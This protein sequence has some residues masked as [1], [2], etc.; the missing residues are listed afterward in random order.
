MVKNRYKSL[1]SNE[2]KRQPHLRQ[3]EVE[4]FLIRKLEGRGSLG[5]NIEIKVENLIPEACQ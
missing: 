1:I 4:T 3:S 2:L 5:S